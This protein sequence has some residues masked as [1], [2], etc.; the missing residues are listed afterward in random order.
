MFDLLFTSIVLGYLD[1]AESRAKGI[2]AAA[3]CALLQ[4]DSDADDRDPRIAFVGAE[5]G[6]NRERQIGVV[7]VC[8]GTQGRAVTDPWMNAIK[9][10]L[11]DQKAL[12]AYIATLPLAKRSG[13]QIEK[14]TPPNSAK[15]QRD[16]MS[17]IEVGVGIIFH[18]TVATI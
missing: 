15:V 7:A 13:Y 1:T 18:I 6:E 12:Y 10:R 3:A 8:R 5:T 16:P 4:M 17:A 14:I 2:P 11:A 9:E